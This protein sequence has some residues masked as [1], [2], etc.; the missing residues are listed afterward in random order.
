MKSTS[1]IDLGCN[2]C[3]FSRRFYWPQTTEVRL[4]DLVYILKWLEERGIGYCW[5]DI[6]RLTEIRVADLYNV[7]FCYKYSLSRADIVDLSNKTDMI[8]VNLYGW[9]NSD[10]DEQTVTRTSE[11]GVH[12]LNQRE[13][14]EFMRRS[15]N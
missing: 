10:I 13:F 8:I 12:S 15:G 11:T 3:N 9:N 6:R 14:C 2:S 5:D 7:T 4:S 1:V